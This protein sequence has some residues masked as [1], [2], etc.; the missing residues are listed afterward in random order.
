MCPFLELKPLPY[1]SINPTD[2]MFAGDPVKVKFSAIQKAKATLRKMIEQLLT[3]HA[4]L[5]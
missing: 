5:T 1:D 3:L 4:A 2:G